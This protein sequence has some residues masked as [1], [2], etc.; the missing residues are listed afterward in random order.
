M[1]SR[2]SG[3]TGAPFSKNVC[4]AAR[5]ATPRPER[6]AD[7]APAGAVPPPRPAAPGC[8]PGGEAPARTARRSTSAYQTARTAGAG[9]SGDAARAVAAPRRAPPK[10]LRLTCCAQ[11]APRCSAEST[12]CPAS[13]ARLPVSARHA[14]AR[15]RHALVSRRLHHERVVGWLWHVLHQLQPSHRERPGVHV[16]NP[17]QRLH[18][19]LV[20]L[21]LGDNLSRSQV[22]W[23]RTHAQGRHAPWTTRGARPA[24]LRW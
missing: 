15:G 20:R 7:G 14:A 16:A 3:V 18:G 12:P 5:Q 23:R 9:V 4:G 1:S 19:R 8:A 17:A 10:P 21:D 6:A 24:G 13:C 22:R 11:Q 2:P